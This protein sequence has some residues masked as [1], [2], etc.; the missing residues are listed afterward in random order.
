MYGFNSLIKVQAGMAE[1]MDLRL[2]RNAERLSRFEEAKGEQQIQRPLSE[3]KL[4]GESSIKITSS[5]RSK[6]RKRTRKH[7]EYSDTGPMDISSSKDSESEDEVATD[8]SS[9][10]KEDGVSD[11]DLTSKSLRH[12]S[13]YQGFMGVRFKKRSRKHPGLKELRP[14]NSLYDKVLS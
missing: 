3:D 2:A 7:D 6:K 9:D 4:A 11:R 1:E 10:E 12:R 14:A 13:H 8:H 5:K